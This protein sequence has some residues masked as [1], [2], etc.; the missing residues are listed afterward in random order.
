MPMPSCDRVIRPEIIYRE[1]AAPRPALLTSSS[2]GRTDYIDADARDTEKIVQE[3]IRTLDVSK[4]VAITMLGILG[5][6]LDHDEAYATVDRLLKAVPS[7]GDFAI[8]DPT[9]SESSLPNGPTLVP[10][11]RPLSVEAPTAS[12]G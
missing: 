1:A 6:I 9:H 7:G 5:H 2:H 8:T 11:Q 10:P 3:A 4:P 12:T